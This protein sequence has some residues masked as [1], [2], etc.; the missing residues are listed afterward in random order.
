MNKLY[1]II[2]NLISSRF[3]IRLFN[4]V[5]A[6]DNLNLPTNKEEITFACVHK[7]TRNYLTLKLLY[8]DKGGDQERCDKFFTKI[9][10]LIQKGKKEENYEI[11]DFKIRKFLEVESYQKNKQKFFSY[12]MAN[13]FASIIDLHNNKL[14]KFLN[15]KFE[16][17]AFYNLYLH[18]SIIKLL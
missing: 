11:L 7:R 1:Y 18:D 6:F 8:F 14:G 2:I 3:S 15:K 4:E 10:K 12:F 17:Y 16:K 5:F 13:R 9:E